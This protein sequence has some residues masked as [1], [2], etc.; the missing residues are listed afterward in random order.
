MVRVAFA[1]VLLAF[2]PSA[3]RACSTCT[4]GDPTLTVMGAEQPNDGRLRFSGALRWRT[5]REDDGTRLVERRLELGLAW[6]PVTR[7]TLSAN[8]PLVS[9]RA[10]FSNLAEER[11]FGLGDVDLR[12]RLLLFRDR[13][14]APRH[15]LAAVV[16]LELPTAIRTSGPFED[17]P[18]QQPGTRTWDPIAGLTYGFFRAPFS[19]STVAVV[20]APLT[21]GVGRV[22]PGASARLSTRAQWQP[23]EVFGFAL[24][25]DARVDGRE[26]TGGQR[27]RASGGAIVYGSAGVVLAPTE[28]VVIDL[29]LSLPAW[30]ALRGGHE[31][32]AVVFVGVAI[33]A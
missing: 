5:E 22:R 1:L 11:S 19:L 16:G 31:E 33:D 15:L 30:Q 32:G 27:E 29:R 14:L 17:D 23:W 12:A 26:H 28:E 20:I 6:S 24:G 7:V 4:V 2:A 9:R 21:E 8:V 25:V 10:R 3:V 18:E 13:A